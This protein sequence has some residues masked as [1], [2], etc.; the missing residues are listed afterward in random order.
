MLLGA[1]RTFQLVDV[2]NKTESGI[3]QLE[4]TFTEHTISGTTSTK[5]SPK[6]EFIDVSIIEGG[7]TGKQLLIG[8]NGHKKEVKEEKV[9]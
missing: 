5:N 7:I 1:T 3:L 2:H 9:S 4:S 8:H 6:D